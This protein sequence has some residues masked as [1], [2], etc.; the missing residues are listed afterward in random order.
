MS[1]LI[2]SGKVK[3]S[4]K[5]IKFNFNGGTCSESSRLVQ[6]GSKLGTLPSISKPYKDFEGWYDA[7]DNLVSPDL[8]IS[9]N[10]TIYAHFK[11]IVRTVTFSG[12]G[13]GTPE[14]STKQVTCGGPFGSL[15]TI[16]DPS[17]NYLF[18]GWY[19]NGVQVTSS[20]VVTFT[21]NVTIVAGWQGKPLTVTLNSYASWCRLEDQTVA[22]KSS[23]YNLRYGDSLDPILSKQIVMLTKPVS[24]YHV[25]GW[26]KVDPIESSDGQS[27]TNIPDVSPSGGVIMYKGMTATENLNL[28]PIVEAVGKLQFSCSPMLFSQIKIFKRSYYPNGDGGDYLAEDYVVNSP[29][30]KT[31]FYITNMCN[32]YCYLNKSLYSNI[33]WGRDY[34][35]SSGSS[36]STVLG[37]NSTGVKIP[38]PYGIDLSAVAQLLIVH[39]SSYSGGALAKL[40]YYGNNYTYGWIYDEPR[41]YFTLI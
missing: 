27:F 30:D 15:L 6:V 41:C 2:S 17:G 28:Y 36:T 39:S 38:I 13:H 32:V 34:K 3:K 31:P 25:W 14:Y 1:N 37:W 5:E 23:T 12:A 33:R 4:L 8:V 16:V 35:S 11:D 9:V 22:G 20:T 21:T 10:M 7:N 18:T 26:S 29:V 19:L 24:I 40:R